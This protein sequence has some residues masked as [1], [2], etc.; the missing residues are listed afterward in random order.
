MTVSGYRERVCACPAGQRCD[1]SKCISCEAGAVPGERDCDFCGAGSAVDLDT[2]RCVPCDGRR[3]GPTFDETCKCP[4]GYFYDKELSKCICK[5]GSFPG[6]P[7]ET[8]QEC[9]PCPDGTLPLGEKCELRCKGDPSVLVCRGR[10]LGSR[11]SEG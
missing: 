10:Q 3:G 6:P 9:L 1:G 7:S 8:P 11:T 2:G 5:R 4:E